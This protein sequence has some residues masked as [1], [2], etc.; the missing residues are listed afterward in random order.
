MANLLTEMLKL[1]GY[2]ARF[3]WIGTRSIPYPQ[4]MPALC[5]NNHAICTLYFGGK[6][7]E[8]DGTESYSPFGENA[9]RIQGKEVMIANGDKYEIKAVPSSTANDNK[10]VTKADFTMANDNL[11][12]KVKV[13]LTG[14]ERT[15]FHQSYQNLPVTSQQEFLNDYL[16]FGNDNMIATNLKNQRP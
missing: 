11:N 6:T 14:N 4:S 10:I 15:E 8:L 16:E 13:M 1:A 12:G 9:F 3:T 2:D 7:Y 5:V